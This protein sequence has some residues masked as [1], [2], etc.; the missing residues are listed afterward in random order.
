MAVLAPTYPAPTRS[1]RIVASMRSE[2][3]TSE[4]QSH[5][6]LVCRLLLEKKKNLEYYIF[7]DVQ[8]GGRHLG[9]LLIA[10]RQQGVSIN[11]IYNSYGS[12]ATPRDF[13]DVLTADVINVV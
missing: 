12:S 10:K 11:I 7:E 1:P 2:E 9:D 4:L 6:D 5:S 13:F 3:H 8:S